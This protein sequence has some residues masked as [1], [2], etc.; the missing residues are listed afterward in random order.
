LKTKWLA[1]CFLEQPTIFNFNHKHIT[2][3]LLLLS[4]NT[5]GKDID[6][7]LKPNLCVISLG[8]KTCQSDVSIEWAASTKH[9][10]CLHI[11]DH[12]E[13]LFCW[14]NKSKGDFIHSLVIKKSHIFELRNQLN[15]QKLASA[16]YKVVYEKTQYRRKRRRAWNLF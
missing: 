14:T 2:I 3:F 11:T 1:L 13:A 5:S 4:F 15:D 7:V 6:L 12:Q 9:S 16:I 10:T 8:E